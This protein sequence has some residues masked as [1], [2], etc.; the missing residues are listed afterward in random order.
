MDTLKIVWCMLVGQE[1]IMVLYKY[2]V[3]ENMVHSSEN[4]SEYTPRVP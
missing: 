3:H 4:V 2:D 1:G